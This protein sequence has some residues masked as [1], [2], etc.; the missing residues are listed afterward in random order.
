MG[1]LEAVRVEVGADGGDV[2]VGRAVLGV[3]LGV[4]EEVP[5]LGVVRIA[6]R[7]ELGRGAAAASRNW[8]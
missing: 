4:R 8:R 5:V 2:G 1:D 3:V 6:D 7:R